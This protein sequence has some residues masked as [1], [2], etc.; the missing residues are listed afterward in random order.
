VAD[1]HCACRASRTQGCADPMRGDRVPPLTGAQG[2]AGHPPGV[3]TL[4][5]GLHARP[6]GPAPA[7]PRPASSESGVVWQWRPSVS[8]RD[9]PTQP[10][11]VGCWSWVRARLLSRDETAPGSCPK[12][13][14]RAARISSPH[15]PLLGSHDGR[16]GRSTRTGAQARDLA[17]PDPS[18]PPPGP[19]PSMGGPGQIPSA[20]A[21]TPRH[22][23]HVPR[24]FHWHAD[25]QPQVFD[26]PRE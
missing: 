18:R 12:F 22:G 2:I 6:V 26:K 14:A 15:P 4:H 19:D 3:H 20:R 8:H 10:G 7:H 5:A 17:V 24:A 11:R 21:C 16:T 1:V 23:M 25:P 9:P 13:L